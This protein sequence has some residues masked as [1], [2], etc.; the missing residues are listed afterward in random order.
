M[1]QDINMCMCSRVQ[2]GIFRCVTTRTTWSAK[3]NSIQEHV[4]RKCDVFLGRK[5]NKA[6]NYLVSL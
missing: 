3:I 2:A 5:W 4:K 1:G 6:W